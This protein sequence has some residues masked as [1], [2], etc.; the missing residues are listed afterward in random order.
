MNKKTILI[1]VGM[2]LVIGIGVLAFIFLNN[3]EPV[4]KCGDGICDEKEKQ[5]GICLKDCEEKTSCKDLCGDGICQEI[6]CMAIGCPCSESIGSCPRDCEQEIEEITLINTI[7]LGDNVARPEIVATDDYIFIVYLD[8]SDQSFK[9]NIYSKDFSSK[10]SEKVIASKNSEYGICTDIRIDSDGEYLYAFY[11]HVNVATDS[12]YLFGKK[13]RLNNNFDLVAETGL[14]STSVQF[15]LAQ[16][17]DEFLDDP[18]VLVTENVVFAITRYMDNLGTSGQTIYRVYKYTKDLVKIEEFNL[19]LSGVADGGSRQAS[20]KEIGGYYYMILPTSVG[21]KDITSKIDNLAPSDILMVKL[22]NNWQIIDSKII[23]ADKDVIENYVM[24]FDFDDEYFYIGYKHIPQPIST[25][26]G[27]LKIY[28]KEFNLVI[29]EEVKTIIPDKNLP[30]NIRMSLEVSDDKIYYSMDNE[31]F[32]YEID[33]ETNYEDSPFGISIAGFLA[34]DYSQSLE[35]MEEAGAGTVRFMANPSWGSLSWQN[36]EYE[37]GKFD[38]SEPD[39]HYLKAKEHKLDIMVNIYPDTPKWNPNYDDNVIMQYP[40]DMDAYLDFIKKAAERYDGDGIQD[41]PGSPVVNSWILGTEMWRGEGWTDTNSGKKWWDGTPEEYATLF[42]ETYKAIKIANS[43]AVLKM[44][45]S[46]PLLDE[47][48]GTDYEDAVYKELR[49]LIQDIPNFSFAYSLHFYP[50]DKRDFEAYTHAIDLAREVLDGNNFYN[51][52]ITIT[53]TACFL[54]KEDSS[55]EENTAKHIIKTYVVGLAH[56]VKNIVWAQ[57]SDGNDE[58]YGKRFEAGLISNPS[59]SNQDKNHYKNLGFYTYK[60]MVEKLEGSDWDNIQT[61]QESDNVYVYKFIKNGEPVWVAWWD[62]FDDTTSSKTI[63][64]D[65]GDINSVKITEAVPKYESGKEVTDY[66]TAFNTETKTV[67]GG[68]VEIILGEIP[69][70][71]EGN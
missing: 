65:V 57:L 66:N 63:S 9:V 54:S 29:E 34:K 64:V 38:W 7:N 70:F 40:G 41:A 30:D 15:K 13:Y 5:K 37:K 45:G 6:V 69:V 68:K 59:M 3:P 58:A 24:G 31:V 51:V 21:A 62:Y 49:K 27:M 4:E 55:K 61:I 14:V 11:E 67:S 10:I 19:D 2:I 35:Y 43:D 23:S 36:V 26:T 52:P 47:E 1:V 48:E 50:G 39:E 12:S 46:N 32:I 18:M 60:L 53:D 44:A 22:N 42:V 28:D 20:I 33:Y 17:G 56:D 8:I 16:N 71:V 25:M